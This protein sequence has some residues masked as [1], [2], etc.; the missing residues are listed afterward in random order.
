MTACGS[1]KVRRNSSAVSSVTLG[2]AS[3]MVCNGVS[4]SFASPLPTFPGL[5]PSLNLPSLGLGLRT[6]RT[7]LG[8]GVGGASFF[9]SSFFSSTGAAA[10]G[11][12]GNGAVPTP[13]ESDDGFR[14]ARPAGSRAALPVETRPIRSNTRSLLSRNAVRMETY[15]SGS[16]TTRSRSSGRMTRWWYSLFDRNQ[17][18]ARETQ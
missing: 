18:N 17:N 9:S 10:A 5:S 14:R 4:A 16:E 12:G 6:R 7:G 1:P 2:T 3:S 11:A 15:A 8:G 13:I